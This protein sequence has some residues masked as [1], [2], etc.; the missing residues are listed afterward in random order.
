MKHII[1][2]SL[3]ISVVMAVGQ[4]HKVP[5]FSFFDVNE[6]GTITRSEFRD[7]KEKLRA[8][9]KSK[10]QARLY[11]FYKI[12]TDGDGIIKKEE[13][14]RYIIIRQSSGAVSDNECL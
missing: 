14:S 1:I 10:K 4:E 11:F 7:G 13:F 8:D 3:C 6:D 12:D 9:K 5:S 2:L